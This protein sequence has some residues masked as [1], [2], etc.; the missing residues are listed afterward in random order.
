MKAKQRNIT[1]KACKEMKQRDFDDETMHN[2][3]NKEQEIRNLVNKGKIMRFKM[4]P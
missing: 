2:V 1:E 4:K 3:D